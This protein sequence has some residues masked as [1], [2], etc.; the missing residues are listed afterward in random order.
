ML[1]QELTRHS[2][3]RNG[4]A[5]QITVIVDS[6]T[7]HSKLHLHVTSSQKS[8]RGYDDDDDRSEENEARLTFK[9]NL[10]TILANDQLKQD[11]E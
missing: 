8:F 6:G 4:R 5:L 1:H 3:K 11:H 7:T 10:L 2:R 9:D